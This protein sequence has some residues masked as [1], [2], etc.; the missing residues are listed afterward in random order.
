MIPEVWQRG[1][2][3]VAAE[4]FH[5]LGRYRIVLLHPVQQN[6]CL[7]IQIRVLDEH[8][9]VVQVKDIPRDAQIATTQHFGTFQSYGFG[10]SENS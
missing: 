7:Q 2:Q 9:T 4:H 3:E 8:Q 1:G 6:D 5:R 10:N